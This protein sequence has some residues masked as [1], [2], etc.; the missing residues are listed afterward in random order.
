M[1][2]LLQGAVYNY[3]K[4]KD[5]S[6]EGIIY[7][8]KGDSKVLEYIYKLLRDTHKDI[9][10]SKSFEEI[11]LIFE[12]YI[13]ESKEYI[14]SK[15]EFEQF[16]E[17]I[18]KLLI[19]FEYCVGKKNQPIKKE[20]KPRKEIQS[21]YDLFKEKIESSIDKDAYKSPLDTFLRA[22]LIDEKIIKSWRSIFDY[23]TNHDDSEEIKENDDNFNSQIATILKE[24]W[25]KN[26]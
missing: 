4:Y 26:Q 13:H 1:E 10:K 6:T 11:K 22:H 3:L 21:S 23:Y 24:L 16:N 7:Q 2:K 5:K 25:E 18:A 20:H 17:I 14:F 12:K 15:E 19:A 8:I 9:Y